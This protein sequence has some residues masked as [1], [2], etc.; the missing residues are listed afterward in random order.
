VSDE[1]ASTVAGEGPSIRDSPI[2]HVSGLTKRYRVVRREAGLAAAVASL[3]HRTYAD[4]VAVDAVSF[5]IAEGELVGLLGPNGAGKTTT[6]KMLAGLLHPTSGVVQVAGYE[7]R[8]RRRDFLR[9]IALVMGQKRQLSWDLPAVDTFELNRVIYD[10]D[11]REFAARLDEFVELLDLGDVVRRPV[12]QLS[13]GERMKCEL[14]A[15]LLH[16]PRVLFLDEPTIGMDVT[17]QARVRSFVREYNARHGATIILTS[18]YMEDVAALCSRV[19]VIDGGKVGFDGDIDGLRRRI[20]PHR[21]VRATL[22]DGASDLPTVSEILRRYDA[23]AGE[24]GRLAIDVAPADVGAVMTALLAIEGI[25]DLEVGDAP[26]EDVMRAM[27]ER[28]VDGHISNAAPKSA[29]RAAAGDG[30]A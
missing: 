1:R 5:D 7:P 17:M 25:R 6:L 14:V 27:F 29:G 20:R 24:A 28:G 13:L 16:R 19:I 8:Q 10:V 26:L 23:H 2:V 21:R 11:R 12:R 18:H 30:E 3:F 22:P 9:S 15:A 4:V